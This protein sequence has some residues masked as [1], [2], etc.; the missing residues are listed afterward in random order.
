MEGGLYYYFSG[1]D[2]KVI[3][4]IKNMKKSILNTRKLIKKKK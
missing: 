3:R 2:V 1:K 4:K